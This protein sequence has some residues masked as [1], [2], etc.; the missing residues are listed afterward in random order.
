MHR[1]RNIPTTG[2]VL[3]IERALT[4]ASREWLNKQPRPDR[5]FGRRVP[6]SLDELSLGD[7]LSLQ[8]ISEDNARKSVEAIVRIVTKTRVPT[9][10]IMLVR[11]D[12]IFGLLAFVTR[13]LER[14]GRMFKSISHEPNEDEIAAGVNDLDSGPFGLVDWYARRMGYKDHDDVLRVPWLRV[15]QTMKIDS[16]RDNYE[17]RLR[18]VINAKYKVKK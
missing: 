17:R 8:G 12:K 16:E 5:L 10:C 4:V 7:L 14:I 11:A 9:W 13:E 6:E 3:A 18:D 2:K 1:K 15:W